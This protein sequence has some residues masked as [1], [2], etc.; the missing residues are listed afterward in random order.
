[1]H[2]KDTILTINGVEP[3]LVKAIKQHSEEMG[4][5]LKGLVLIDSSYEHN[6]RAKDESGFFKEIFCNFDDHDEVQR[7]LKP[8][9]D[10]LLAVTCRFE[11]AVE[12]L[13]QIIPFIPY[14]HTT[15]ETSLIWATEKSQ[16]RDR[17]KNYDEN[18]VPRYQYV[19]KSDMDKLDELLGDFKFP[20]IVKPSG[21]SAS[22]LVSSCKTLQEVKNALAEVFSVIDDVYKMKLRKIK[23]RVLVE[24]MMVGD[25]YSTDAYVS[26]DGK[27][28]CLPLVKCVTAHMMG[29]TGFY[30]Y[31]CDTPVD[32]SE[33]EA[34]KAFDAARAAIKALNVSAT[35]THIELFQTKDG[36]KIIELGAR[37]GGYREDMY[38]EAFGIEHY[39]NDLAVRM[40]GEPIMPKE[41]I[42]YSMNFNM[43]PDEEGTITSIEGI[44]EAQKLESVIYLNAH[45]KPG[46][47]A[48]FA[49]NGGQLVVDGVLSNK[50]KAELDKDLARIEKLVQIKVKPA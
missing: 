18:L 13:R 30:C 17:L 36:W 45:A 39:Y 1:M 9:V 43:Y 12:P 5:E 16:M 41:S 10:R 27:I 4:I 28:Y 15:S 26:P 31:R 20:V 34:E 33:A 14:V 8:Y 25:M 19:Q 50:D 38:R 46:D 6:K 49:N 47:K 35:T 48:L 40:G 24:E 23:P 2:V 44:E 32:L 3:G 42:R 29:K 22:L 21:L 37:L 11:S 7:V